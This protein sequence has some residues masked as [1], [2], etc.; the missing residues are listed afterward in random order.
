M[1]LRLLGPRPAR[2]TLTNPVNRGGHSA[3]GEPDD[4]SD[5]GGGYPWLCNRMISS[6]LLAAFICAGPAGR[7]RRACNSGDPEISS[8]PR[9]LMR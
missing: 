5:L 8:A 4:L 3:P 6:S 7:R 2:P 9:R 1:I